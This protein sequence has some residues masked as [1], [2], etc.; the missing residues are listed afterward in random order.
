MK[1]VAK[2]GIVAGVMVLC[3]TACGE[4]RVSVSSEITSAISQPAEVSTEYFKSDKGLNHFFQKYNEIAEYPFE[5]EQIQQG[6]VRTKALISTGDFYIE[7]VNSQNGLEI[8]IDDG[9]EESAALYPVFRDFLKVMDDSLFDEQ[10]EQAWS[11]IK[12]IGTKYMYDGNYA[13]N[14]LKMNYS[15]V[16]F[17]GSR[18]VKVHIYGLQYSA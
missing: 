16:E 6:N 3:L 4:S 9:P 11:D 14:S 17:Q 2:I 1:G 12:E 5:E 8:L 10:I 15:N 13:L 18:Q 7:M